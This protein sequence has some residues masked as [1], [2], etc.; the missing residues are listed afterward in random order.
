MNLKLK[1]TL[2]PCFLI[3]LISFT[4]AQ[5]RLPKI[6]G[7][8]MVLQRNQVVPVWGWAKPGKQVMVKFSGQQKNA[9]ADDQGY[10]KIL[11]FPLKTSLQPQK[12]VIS[13]DT[14]TI[15][16]TN[17]LVGEVWL[18][19][20][21]SNMEYLMKL[22]HAKPAKGI[23]S[24]AL[25]I[26]T[27]NPQIRLFK[28][29]KELST[30]DVTTTGWNESGGESLEQFSAPGYYFAKTLYAKLHIPIGMIVS[31]WGGSRIEPWTP[32]SG[33]ANLPIFKDSFVK[34]PI[35]IDS[36]VPGKNYQSMIQ[37][38]APYALRGFLW[39]Q[40]ESNC[41]TNDGMRYADKM[42]AL[43]E[44]WRKAWRNDKL[45]FYSVLIAPYYY[46]KRKDHV[47]H[48]PETLAEFWE[49]Q[50]QSLKIPGTEIISV[51]D[52]VDKLSDIHPSYK[53][54]VGRRL[55]MVALA[56]DYGYSKVIYSGPRYK[57]MQIKA[58]KVTLFFT[59]ANGLKTN[60]GKAV[61]SF[62]I[63]GND[64][65]FVIATAEIAGSKIIVSNPAIKN[66]VAIR[67]AW[68][69][70]AQPNLVNNAWLPALP[71]RTDGKTWKYVKPE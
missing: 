68:N 44:S 41:M 42:Q 67:F 25:E 9:I 46:S 12:M 61:D 14:T 23:D 16:L 35:L 29:K 54:E 18:C 43:V 55:A 51:T 27:H 4:Q 28:V 65:K 37:P 32:P 69:E 30:P 36:V 15:N 26:L 57:K 10:W 62:T 38:L 17:I 34:E 59:N 21:Q 48:T 2:L 33:Y 1:V 64:G 7:S 45:P 53:W 39:Y 66:P 50:I 6:I 52:L 20:G 58:D 24:A 40:G 47:P 13:S 31:S 3:L 60:D 19:S 70:A 71:F 22:V 56:K 11:L 8:N 49:A 5:I 63:A